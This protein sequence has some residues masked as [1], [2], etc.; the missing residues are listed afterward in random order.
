MT[1][2]VVGQVLLACKMAAKMGTKKEVGSHHTQT[3]SR[4]AEAREVITC[5]GTLTSPAL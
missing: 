1:A 2:K 4:L 5:K 3:D